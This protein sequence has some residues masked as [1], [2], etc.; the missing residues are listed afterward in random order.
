MRNVTWGDL[1]TDDP[2]FDISKLIRLWPNTLS[3]AIRPIG[4]S[5]FGDVFFQRRA[6]NIERLDVL[7]GGVS[8]VASTFEEFAELMNSPP[9][10]GEAL[11][12]QGV[13][14]LL[15]RGLVRRSH[16]C[17]AP[18]PH[19]VHSGRIDWNRVVVMDAYPWHSICSQL[20]DGANRSSNAT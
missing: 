14:L 18:V 4:M 15:E 8:P 9:W 19:P 1:F 10:Q 16:E 7:E 20:L 6:G 3:G 12:S 2:S 5:A 17:F 13:A 11:L